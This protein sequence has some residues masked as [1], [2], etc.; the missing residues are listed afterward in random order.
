MGDR[1]VAAAVDDIARGAD[2]LKK[3]LDTDLKK[4]TAIN[5]QARQAFVGE[6]DQLSKDAKALRDRLN[7]GQPSSAETARLLARA[8]KVQAILE[9]H[10]VPTSGTAWNGLTPR[11]QT[12]AGAYGLA[13]P[14]GTH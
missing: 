6:V 13:W 1:E 11:I 14:P 5:K 4:D 10:K 2:R 3:S 9:S 12:I 7:D 8:T